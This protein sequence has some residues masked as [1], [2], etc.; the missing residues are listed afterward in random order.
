MLCR[1]EAVELSLVE[2]GHTAALSDFWK[3]TPTNTQGR[4]R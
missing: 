1:V 4:R 2:A 3:L